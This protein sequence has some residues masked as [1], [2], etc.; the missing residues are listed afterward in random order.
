MSQSRYQGILPRPGTDAEGRPVTWLPFREVTQP[1]GRPV[2][3]VT[4]VGDRLD[5]FAERVI[6]DPG[7]WWTIADA[8]PWMDPFE[9][10]ALPGRVL[11]IPKAGT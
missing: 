10:A 6:G 8:N 11:S 1:P 4:R 2:Y 9:T 5:L 7:L 3:V